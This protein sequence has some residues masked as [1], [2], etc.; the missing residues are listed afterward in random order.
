MITLL[1]RDNKHIVAPTI[2]PDGTSQV[3]K[4]PEWALWESGK[5]VHVTW[6][7]EAEREIIDILSLSKLC[8]FSVL[9]IP[10]LPYARQDKQVSNNSTFNLLVF[11]ELINSLDTY[12]T[13]YDVHS[14]AACYL[15]GLY[16]IVPQYFHKKVIE[17]VKPN[18]I[19]FPDTGAAIRY[20]HLKD[21][22][23][24]ILRK[25]GTKLLGK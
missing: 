19:I 24:I 2:F 12:P 20:P 9:N 21:L 4:L 8:H 14:D 15:D 18:Y 1:Q 10:Y 16:N 3:W 13:T 7:F 17:K 6:N 11:S 22:P 5:Q 23:H 25:L